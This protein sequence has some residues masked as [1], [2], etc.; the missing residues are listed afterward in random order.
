MPNRPNVMAESHYKGT[1]FSARW[2]Y[3]G[4]QVTQC[5]ER[6][7]T[8]PTGRWPNHQAVHCD[9]YRRQNPACHGK[10]TLYIHPS[11]LVM[12]CWTGEH[13]MLFQVPCVNCMPQTTYLWIEI[14]FILIGPHL[15]RCM[16]LLLSPAHQPLPT[17]FPYCY[18]YGL[19]IRV[20]I[21]WVGHVT[22]G[23]VLNISLRTLKKVS[24]EHPFSCLNVT[25]SLFFS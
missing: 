24:L 11:T 3:S 10:G 16:F 6:C 21:R 14:E 13:W 2:D 7:T 20:V 23:K 4:H 5:C 12:G 8:V 19:Y 9:R 25:G 17:Q 1:R 18:L 22:L 15:V